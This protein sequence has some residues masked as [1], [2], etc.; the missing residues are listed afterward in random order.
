MRNTEAKMTFGFVL[1]VAFMVWFES[2]FYKITGREPNPLI[3]FRTGQVFIGADN[4]NNLA[5]TPF[6][7][8][9][10]NPEDFDKWYKKTYG[11]EAVSVEFEK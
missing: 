11:M 3:S 4:I 10:L 5:L 7:L 6:V 8:R 2:N 9:A 1:F